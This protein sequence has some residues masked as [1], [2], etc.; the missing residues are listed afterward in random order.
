MQLSR[1]HAQ[2]GS[3]RC[4][5]FMHSAVRRAHEVNSHGRQR[6]KGSCGG[7]GWCSAVQRGV[8]CTYTSPCLTMPSSLRAFLPPCPDLP[9]G[10]ALPRPAVHW[11]GAP[12]RWLL[13]AP[14]FLLHGSHLRQTAA[15]QPQLRM[16][17]DQ[18]RQQDNRNQS[19]A[20]MGW[21]QRRRS[22]TGPRCTCAAAHALQYINA[23]CGAAGC[24]WRCGPSAT[25]SRS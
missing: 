17:C 22:S 1:V 18:Q 6:T 3:Q 25:A 7:C 21:P 13:F 15:P 4:Q 16:Q 23:G 19:D 11:P 24:T 20:R 12:A 9:S 10:H 2:L 14:R 8:N 5:K